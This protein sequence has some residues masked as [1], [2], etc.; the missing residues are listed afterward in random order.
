VSPRVR[1]EA[2]IPMWEFQGDAEGRIIVKKPDGLKS[3]GGGTKGRKKSVKE[4]GTGLR[5]ALIKSGE[6]I[7]AGDSFLRTKVRGHFVGRRLS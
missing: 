6:D 5:A 4:I 3:Q 7:V 2:F 1:A